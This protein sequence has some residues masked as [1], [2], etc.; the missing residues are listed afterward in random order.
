MGFIYSLMYVASELPA[1]TGPR[2]PGR[3]A[4]RDDGSIRLPDPTTGRKHTKEVG[5]KRR[6]QTRPGR[7]YE[8]PPLLIGAPPPLRPP[9]RPKPLR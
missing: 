9:E 1:G 3:Y 4:S 5:R 6:P 2:G 8:S 7:M